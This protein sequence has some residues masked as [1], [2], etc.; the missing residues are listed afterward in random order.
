[1]V[2]APAPEDLPMPGVTGKEPVLREG[3]RQERRMISCNQESPTST[4]TT[5]PA[6]SRSRFAA[7][8]AV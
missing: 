6:A 7:I 4:N 5:Q 1:M 2:G 3:H 8:H